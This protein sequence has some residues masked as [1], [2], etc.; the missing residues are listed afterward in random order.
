[1]DKWIRALFVF[2]IFTIL[3]ACSSATE[4]VETN[5]DE[6][7]VETVD[8]TEPIIEDRYFNEQGSFSL[9]LPDGWQ[10]AGPIE[11]T[12]GNDV[13]YTLYS[14]GLEPGSSGGPGGSNIIIAENAALTIEEFVQAQCSTCP[15]API[16]DIQLG[17]TDAKQTTIGG[18][19]VPVSVTWTFVQHDGKLIGLKI[20]D[21]ET[22]EPITEVLESILLH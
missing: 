19:G 14:V 22:L 7:P 13:T 9:V 11:A 3:Q 1:M 16:E 20:H 2:A 18:G 10:V 21:P 4:P 5:S 15:L 17:D 12:A 6:T 8:A